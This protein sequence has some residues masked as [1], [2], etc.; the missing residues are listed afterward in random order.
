[1]S[2]EKKNS[3]SLNQ[4]NPGRCVVGETWDRNTCRKWGRRR[5]GIFLAKASI[6]REGN[7]CLLTVQK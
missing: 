1:M 6:K 3:G 4:Y 7:G 2:S 5:A